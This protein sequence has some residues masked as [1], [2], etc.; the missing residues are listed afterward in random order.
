MGC[1]GE[2]R[3][4]SVPVMTA[5]DAV[6]HSEFFQRSDLCQMDY[7]IGA[8]NLIDNQISGWSGNDGEGLSP[9]VL[10]LFR[11]SL[12]KQGTSYPNVSTHNQGTA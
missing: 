10:F 5:L 7:P 8:S 12:R 4:Y 6:I 11:A 3:L 1:A 2:D 9:N